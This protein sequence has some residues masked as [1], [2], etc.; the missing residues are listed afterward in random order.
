MEL[1]QKL[2]DLRKSKGLTQLELAE[3]LSVSR[4]AISRWEVGAA[5][6]SLDNLINL[7]EV[8]GVPL[9]E[10]VRGGIDQPDQFQGGEI[11]V[12]QAPYEPDMPDA[13]IVKPD[14]PKRPRTPRPEP[15]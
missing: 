3:M 2:S 4:Q 12:P 9:D 13:Y 7:S 11:S 14:K 1:K 5:V 10:L 6:P 15:S 8:Y